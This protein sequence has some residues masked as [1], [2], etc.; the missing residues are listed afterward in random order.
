[1]KFFNV[2]M[3][4]GLLWS[5]LIICGDLASNNNAADVGEIPNDSETREKSLYDLCRKLLV[6]H[7]AENPLNTMNFSCLS[8][9]DQQL[10]S[11]NK[12]DVIR[13]LL[14]FIFHC[15]KNNLKEAFK[16]APYI[17]LTELNLNNN[18]IRCVGEEIKELKDL[19]HIRLN[20][21]KLEDFPKELIAVSKLHFIDLS[22]NHI[23]KVPDEIVQLSSLKYLWLWKNP[24]DRF[25]DVT[26][27]FTPFALSVNASLSPKS[28]DVWKVGNSSIASKMVYSKD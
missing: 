7:Y 24:L 22:E 17:T 20:Q 1:M 12:N 13:R 9:E 23:K 11:F 4:V 28:K 15:K 26:E 16:V 19:T 25:P 14:F 18:Y 21:N 6:L 27:R 8:L 10:A 3:M 5:S 2:M